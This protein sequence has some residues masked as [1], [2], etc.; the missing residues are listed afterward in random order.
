MPI[1]ALELYPLHYLMFG[2][3][4]HLKY[5]LFKFPLGFLTVS[6][7][8]LGTWSGQAQDTL[9][10]QS[11][12]KIAG[13]LKFAPLSLFDLD[14]TIQF[15][16]EYPLN[17]RWTLQAEAG[18]GNQYFN[19]FHFNSSYHRDREIWRARTEGRYYLSRHR[20]APWGGYIAMEVLYKR[21][22]FS[23]QGSIG[24]ECENGICAYFERTRYKIFKDVVGYHLKIGAQRWIG[25]RITLEGYVGL[26]ARRIFIK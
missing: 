3:E 14:N 20:K 8:F 25:K 7:F 17:S 5:I 13:I 26:G 15:G 19:I 23:E 24:R 22:T 10:N 2:R 18:Y 21:I 9:R 6:I 16:Y 1:L 12:R 4:L 11:N